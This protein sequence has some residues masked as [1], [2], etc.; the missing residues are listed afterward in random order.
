MKTV[1][2]FL[3]KIDE[4]APGD[5]GVINI[6]KDDMEKLHKEGE[7]K[8]QLGGATYILKTDIAEK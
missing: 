8:I 6:S 2:D 3:S 5:T 1:N 4:H 7:V